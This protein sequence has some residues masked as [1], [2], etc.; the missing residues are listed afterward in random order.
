MDG[1][2]RG[3]GEDE[4]YPEKQAPPGWNIEV[5]SRLAGQA[6]RGLLRARRGSDPG[7]ERGLGR[8]DDETNDGIDVAEP[9]WVCRLDSS[10]RV[11][12]R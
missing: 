12:R 3:G 5:G 11:Q 9:R 8:R 4:V 6:G 2:E 10:V 7:R 1:R